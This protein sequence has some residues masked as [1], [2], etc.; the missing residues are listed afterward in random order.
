MKNLLVAPVKLMPP[1]WPHSGTV[2]K[3]AEGRYKASAMAPIESLN[4]MAAKW[5]ESQC[6]TTSYA[7][8]YMKFLAGMIF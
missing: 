1:H 2:A 3:A 7:H 4:M 8:L 5:I 6:T